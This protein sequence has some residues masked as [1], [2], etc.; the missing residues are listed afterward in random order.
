MSYVPSPGS[1]TS[2]EVTA[3]GQETRCLLAVRM[4]A[5]HAMLVARASYFRLGTPPGLFEADE[6]ANGIHG[7]EVET[8]LLLAL[9]PDLVRREGLADF[10]GLPGRWQTRS[11]LLGVE[12]PVGIG[13]LAQDLHGQGVCGNAAR[14]DAER[15]EALLE[16]LAQGL[17]RLVEEMAA[18]PLSMLAAGPLDG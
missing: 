16:H 8:S 9:R 12:K 5:A 1:A 6:L 14:A 4:R 3:V 18:T 11:R 7:G 17:D 13:W 15:G 2:G 10:A